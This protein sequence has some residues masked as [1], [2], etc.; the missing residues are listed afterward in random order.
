MTS[1][2]IDR[3]LFL[4]SCSASFLSLLSKLKLDKSSLCIAIKTLS[5]SNVIVSMAFVAAVSK[6]LWAQ[7]PNNRVNIHVIFRKTVRRYFKQSVSINIVN[8]DHR[9]ILSDRETATIIS[10]K[11]MVDLYWRS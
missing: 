9:T 5:S 3:F 7:A 1:S 11:T 8:G 10:D 2:S 4:T 6:R